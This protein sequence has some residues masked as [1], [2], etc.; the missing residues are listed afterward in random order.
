[1]PCVGASIEVK[2]RLEVMPT[3][4]PDDHKILN[5]HVSKWLH[6]RV[7]I[8]AVKRGIRFP[9]IVEEALKLWL[10]EEAGR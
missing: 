5:T 6:D 7:R 2:G 4:I 3:H 8:A 1:M 10:K 9:E